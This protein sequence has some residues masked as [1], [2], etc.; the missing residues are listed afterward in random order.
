MKTFYI[1]KLN[2]TTFSLAKKT[3][4][5]IYLLLNTIYRQD[6]SNL[7]KAFSLFN[8]LCL[9]INNDFFNSYLYDKLKDNEYYTKYRSVHM[10]NNYLDDEV[11]KMVIGNS[12]I[13]IKSNKDSNVFLESINDLNNLFIC[14]FNNEYYKYL[15]H[16]R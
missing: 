1:F 6:K 7:I 9:P 13:K 8:E 5:N 12:H 3:P 4:Y 10:Y 15:I 2:K 14:D 11:S 16:K